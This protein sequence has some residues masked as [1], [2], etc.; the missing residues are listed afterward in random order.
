[1]RGARAQRGAHV[2]PS[3]PS[4]AHVASMVPSVP[5]MAA[6]GALAT[7]L[8]GAAACGGSP[9]PLPAGPPPEYE[10]P[11]AYDG[12]IGEA[13]PAPAPPAP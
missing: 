11:R 1:M 10:T 2:P 5:S 7:C 9:K 4:V 3:I 12:D 8:F 6:I 13:S